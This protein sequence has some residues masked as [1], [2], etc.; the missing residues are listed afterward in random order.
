M[1]AR[2]LLLTDFSEELSTLTQKMKEAGYQVHIAE[3]AAE[4]AE[5]IKKSR[6]DLLIA[7]TDYSIAIDLTEEMH[8]EWQAP[9]F[10]ILAS[11]GDETS[12]SLRKHPGIIGVF[13]RP[14]N[15]EKLLERAKDLFG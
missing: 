4:A 13:F 10:L 6:R 3:S 14:L 8:K 11:A 9:T 12:A 2:V 15:V 5:Q 7:A 1:D